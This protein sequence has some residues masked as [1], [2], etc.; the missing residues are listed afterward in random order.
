MDTIINCVCGHSVAVREGA[1]KRCICGR[2]LFAKAGDDGTLRAWMTN[3]DRHVDD[4]KRPEGEGL[5]PQRNRKQR[6]G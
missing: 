1:K 6:N 3:F 4:G 2:M 5:L